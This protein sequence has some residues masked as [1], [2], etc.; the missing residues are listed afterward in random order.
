M[1][2]EADALQSLLTSFW[3]PA[4]SFLRVTIGPNP[5]VQI[6]VGARGGAHG[7]NIHCPGK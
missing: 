6:L 1:K 4:S 5:G 2:D 7:Q 3:D